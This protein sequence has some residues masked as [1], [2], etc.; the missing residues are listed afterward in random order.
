L[1]GLQKQ[2][3]EALNT[4]FEDIAGEGAIHFTATIRDLNDSIAE[5]LG[6]ADGYQSNEVDRVV[7]FGH[8]REE[9]ITDIRNKVKE[10]ATTDFKTETL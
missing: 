3:E 1:D 5:E 4:S 2:F 8:K 7:D 9:V 10:M 6:K